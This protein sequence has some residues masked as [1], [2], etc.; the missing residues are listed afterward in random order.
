MSKKWV[1]LGGGGCRRVVEILGG[2]RGLDLGEEA[3][4]FGVVGRAHQIRLSAKRRLEFVGQ[5]EPVLFGAGTEIA[6]RADDFLA[7]PLGSD[8]AFDEEIVGVGL[9]LV[10]PRGF[11]DIHILDTN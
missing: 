7:R 10:V 9:A 2:G 8:D 6:E 5:G 4:Y 3:L 1:I 11:A